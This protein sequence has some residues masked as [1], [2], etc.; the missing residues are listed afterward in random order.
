MPITFGKEYVPSGE[1]ATEPMKSRWL[2]KVRTVD[3][4]V[5]DPMRTVLSSLPEITRMP[6][7]VKTVAVTG[8]ACA[9][10]VNR[11]TPLDEFQILMVPSAL[12][13]TIFC[14]SALKTTDV[15]PLVCPVRV[16]KHAQ[17]VVDHILMV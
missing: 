9:A 14:Q 7:G 12:P 13:E 2:P 8:N 1:N 11:H 16:R 10:I 6:S 4:L 15:T 17:L 5:A 3:P